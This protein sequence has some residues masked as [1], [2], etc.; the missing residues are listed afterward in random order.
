[1]DLALVQGLEAWCATWM[2]IG[3]VLGV[4]LDIV[5]RRV[6]GLWERRK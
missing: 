4:V 6:A 5:F 3:I 2:V 1:V